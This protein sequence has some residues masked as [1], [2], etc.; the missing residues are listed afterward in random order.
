MWLGERT[1]LDTRD[2][3]QFLKLRDLVEANGYKLCRQRN[4]YW[5]AYWIEDSDNDKIPHDDNVYRVKVW[6]DTGHVSVTCIGIESV[7]AL[8]DGNYAD[9]SKLPCWMQERL[10]VL[11]VT[12]PKPPTHIIEG[13][14]RRIN[15]DT[16]WVF[17]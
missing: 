8:V 12:S 13:V 16:Y 3:K 15:D 5:I 11:S 2:Q 10:A 4:A 1:W 6:P 9:T 17:C 7:D 14:G